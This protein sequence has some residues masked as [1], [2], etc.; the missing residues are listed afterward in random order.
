M[1]STP[2]STPR[3]RFI[4]LLTA[5]LLLGVTEAMIGPYLVLFGAERLRLSAF[6]I[7][8]FLS[9]TS[10]S[11]MAVSLLLG[12]RYDRRPGRQPAVLAGCLAGTGYLL[13]LTGP[14][15]PLLLLIAVLFLGPGIALFPQLFALA[16]S[17]EDRTESPSGDGSGARTPL[18]R[19][20]WSLAWAIGP[21][22]GA[23]L[24]GGGGYTA[25]LAATAAGYCL[26]VV[27]VLG[28][29]GFPYGRVAVREPAGGDGGPA[30]SA[31]AAVLP[32]AA[33]T[34]FHTAMF[35]G[36]VVLPLYVTQGL[37][38]SADT[39]GW[40]FSVCA[41][42]EIPAALALLLPGRWSR[43]RAILLGM[44]LMTVHLALLAVFTSTL[45]L[46]LVHLARGV[47]IAVVGALG[48]SHMQ[49]LFPHAP[50]RATTLFANTAA[51][52]AL[53]SGLAAGGLSQVLG[54]HAALVCCAVVSAV[55]WLL[56][57]LAGRRTPVRSEEPDGAQTCHSSS[58][59]SSIAPP[60]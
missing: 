38:G 50:G 55:A 29:G 41:A 34:L 16:R 52:G 44:A 60:S 6:Q 40:M 24:L 54:H 10:V 30:V 23:A 58:R 21:L 15:Y 13:L 18:L 4:I 33:F 53:M 47:A 51:A 59:S 5:V 48:I 57:L 12:R 20:V 36:A 19:S 14:P 37:G 11:G 2:A 45:A 46:V 49:N 9:L 31:R 1:R 28:L 3:R 56:F 43:R 26:M 32:V 17:H 25:V 42:A 7:G 22:A 39:V 8:L 35:S 27:T